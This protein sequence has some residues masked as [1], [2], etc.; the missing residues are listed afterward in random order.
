MGLVSWVNLLSIYGVLY[1]FQSAT[2]TA[3]S[4]SEKSD[5]LRQL[6][7]VSGNILP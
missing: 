3:W 1:S 7:R 2:N 4:S 5:I 6:I